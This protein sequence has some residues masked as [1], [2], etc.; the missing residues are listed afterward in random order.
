[1]SI[2]DVDY[3]KQNSI[4]EN[5]TFIVDSKFRNQEEYPN[6][7]NYVVNFDIPFKN[8]FGIEILDV[9]VP[10]TMYNIDNDTNKL[11]IYINTTKNAITN[12]FDMVE[13]LEWEKFDNIRNIQ[14][15]SEIINYILSDN[16]KNNTII[17]S[18]NNYGITNL[19]KYN[20]ISVVDILNWNRIVIDVNTIDNDSNYTSIYN[21]KL[22]ED[23]KINNIFQ[24]RDQ[25]NEYDINNLRTYNVIPIIDSEYDEKYYLKWYNIGTEQIENNYGLKWEYIG[26]T[27]P[28]HGNNINNDFLINNIIDNEL[29]LSF[30]KFE[31]L[32]IDISNKNNYIEIIN[33]NIKNYYKPKTNINV[34]NKWTNIDIESNYYQEYEN[35]N[36]GNEIKNKIY[37]NEELIFTNEKLNDL[38]FDYNNDINIFIKIIT[39]LKWRITN[40]INDSGENL[41]DNSEIITLIRNKSK[42]ITDIIDLEISDFTIFDKNFFINN[43]NSNSY[44]LIDNIIWRTEY[45][46]YV[47]DGTID[48]NG[49]IKKLWLINNNLVNLIKNTD[50]YEQ[51]YNQ[52]IINEI[53]WNNLNIENDELLS[54][55][56]IIV[57][58]YYYKILPS[59]HYISNIHYYYAKDI[60]NVNSINDY[61]K[62]LDLFFELFIIEIPIGNYTLN[63]LI[64]K[65]NTKFRE[66]INSV[67]LN[68][69]IEDVNKNTIL[70]DIDNFELELQCSGNTIPADIQNILKFEG[71]RHIIFDMNKSTLNK[72]LGFYSKVSDNLEFINNYSYLNINKINAYE[73]FYHSIKIIDSNKYR[74]IAPGIVYLI[75]SEYIIL[76]C[77]EIEEHL[78]GSLSY[79][80][81]TI[82]LAKIRVTNWGL[83]EESTSY[84][85]L[86]LREFHPIG[87]L[88][89]ITL[90][91]EN[92]EGNLYDFRGVNHNIVFAVHYYSAKQKQNFEKS[93]INPEYKMNFMDYKYSQEEKEEESDIEDDENNSLI[94]IEEYKKMEQKYSDKK[95]ENGYE[96][97]YNKIRKKLYDNINDDSENE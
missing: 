58:N 30:E 64:V 53:E 1:M 87:K 25:L 88:S 26:N 37:N 39:G 36:L 45:T 7:N 54:N 90:Q 76:K 69:K 2:E 84:L 44:I 92:A 66:N 41:I 71:N 33:N 81:N 86:K 22:S 97:D 59:Y 56:I 17:D 28:I 89:K 47:P 62:L 31:S 67:I 51:K 82:G 52:I 93:I 61:Q 60:L 24:N 55:T 35:N 63:K 20:Y 75:G 34:G 38:N 91:F 94:N 73:K 65:L 42:N 13:G 83:N 29:E 4:K 72:T 80:K 74:I 85:K 10:K 48:I 21:I 68:R 9:S 12:Y 78:Y 95:F 96:L 27:K 16:L 40:S 43:I 57:D 11:Y 23:L 18:I 3:M 5:Y 77:P 6:P 32:N 14:E 70:I 49:N 46:A 79:T 8:V 19:N 15:D 50:N